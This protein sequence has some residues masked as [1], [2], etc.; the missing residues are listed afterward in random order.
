MQHTKAN[1]LVEE[2]LK[3]V[4]DLFFRTKGKDYSSDEDRLHNFKVGL[5]K[6]HTAMERWYEWT[7]KHWD[8]IKTA[9]ERNPQDPASTKKGEGLKENLKDLAVYAILGYLLSVEA[10][11]E[12]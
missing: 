10:S 2:F 12:A 5:L 3:E 11:D 8:A 7:H 9:I 1:K 4:E 6:N